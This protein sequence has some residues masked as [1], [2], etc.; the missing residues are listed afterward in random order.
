M[1]KFV[2]LAFMLGLGCHDPQSYEDGTDIGHAMTICDQHAHPTGTMYPE[3]GE[4]PPEYDEGWDACYAVRS[5][6]AK[7]A[8]A[9]AWQESA[10]KDAKDKQ[11]VQRVGHCI[12]KTDADTG[13]PIT[14][15][16]SG[17]NQ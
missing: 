9:K 3:G 16:N 4:P 14:L 7:G 13:K 10:E 11:F 12:T 5:E 2:I 17:A 15:C 8:T 6:W 1:G